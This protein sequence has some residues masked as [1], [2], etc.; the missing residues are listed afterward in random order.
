MSIPSFRI[1]SIDC[2]QGA[3]RAVRYNVDGN[4][5]LTC[6]SDKSIKLWNPKKGFQLRTYTGHGYEVLDARG[7]CDNSQIASCGMDKTVILWDVS[8]GTALRKWRGHAGTVNCVIFNEDSSC[9]LSGSIDGTIK[10]WDGRSKRNE[11]IQTLDVFKDS[12]TSIDVSDHE[13]IA[14]SADKTIRRFDIRNGAL[15]TDYVGYPISSLCFTRDGQCILVNTNGGEPI[16]L[17]DK[18]S[19]ELLQEFL[20][21]LNKKNY[22]IDATLDHKDKYVI[23]GSENG[24]AYYWDL[25]EGNVVAKLD[26]GEKENA[27]MVNSN[28]TVHSLSQHPSSAH[29]LTA[30]GGKIH[31]WSDTEEIQADDE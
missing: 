16:K 2:K 24:F 30:T 8:I 21:A 26:H 27:P 3:V 4:Y 6:G 29:L 28:I 11:P 15:F 31:I 5:C 19:G 9:V 10:I 17:F 7:S 23:S 22:R 12:V 14:G 18:S 13:I 25:V 20:G 1:Q